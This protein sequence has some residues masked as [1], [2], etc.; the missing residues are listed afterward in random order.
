[1]TKTD[2]WVMAFVCCC[3]VAFVGA[4]GFDLWRRYKFHPEPRREMR[5]LVAH[6][7]PNDSRAQVQKFILARRYRHLSLQTSGPDLWRLNTPPE[8]GAA[9]WV[10]LIEWN[11]DRVGALRLRTAANMKARPQETAPPDEVAPGWGWKKSST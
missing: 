2:R 10:L 1:M 11:K 8:W 6:V 4:L 9:N 7:A 3:L 5:D